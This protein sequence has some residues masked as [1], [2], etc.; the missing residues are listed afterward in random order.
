MNDQQDRVAG[1]P[2]RELAVG[3]ALHALEPAEESLVAAHLPDCPICAT[4]AAQTEEVGAM[5]GFSVPQRIPSVELER[6]VLGVT[7]D[8]RAAPVV[9]L[10]RPVRSA[11][12]ITEPS[13][14]DFSG[15]LSITWADVVGHADVEQALQAVGN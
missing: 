12:H 1:C 10:A 15:W 5:L 11:R 3:W 4:T 6:R 7:G 13:E 2:N 14:V 9:H 8:G